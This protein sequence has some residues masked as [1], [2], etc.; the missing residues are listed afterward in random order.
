MGIIKTARANNTGANI[1]NTYNAALS[2]INQV[3]TSLT[4]LNTQIDNMKINPDDFTEEDWKEVET[5][6][7]EVNQKVQEL[8]NK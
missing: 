4:T 1:L 8:A 3:D 6:R 2:N 5:L 7:D